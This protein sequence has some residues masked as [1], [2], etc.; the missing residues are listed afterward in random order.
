LNS[1]SAGGYPDANWIQLSTTGPINSAS[2]VVAEEPD[3]V[4]QLE[5]TGSAGGTATGDTI[6]IAWDF[7]TTQTGGSGGTMTWSVDFSVE[8]SGLGSGSSFETSGTA[9]SF[10]EITG[11]NSIF[12]ASGGTLSNWSMSVDIL[13]TSS[14]TL[15][16]PLDGTLDL[17]TA[18][19]VAPEPAS[20][21]LAG[22]GGTFLLFLRKRKRA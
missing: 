12:L 13:S 8:G 7:T 6:P 21:L 2:I 14:F 22:A 5:G 11:S 20:L 18:A 16:V 1:V 15:N 17:N 3:P 19:S 10:G 4:V 9:V